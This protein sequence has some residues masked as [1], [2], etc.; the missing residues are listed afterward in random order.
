VKILQEKEMGLHE[1]LDVHELL[2]F[3]NTCLAKSTTMSGLAQDQELKTLL[4]Q[5]ITTTKEQIQELK[6]FLS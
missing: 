4:N 3:K 2:N 1:T 6:G 5:D